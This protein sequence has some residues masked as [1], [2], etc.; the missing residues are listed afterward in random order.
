MRMDSPFLRLFSVHEVQQCGSTVGHQT[1]GGRQNWEVEHSKGNLL[2]NDDYYARVVLY[3]WHFWTWMEC[4]QEDIPPFALHQSKIISRHILIIW[5]LEI[6]AHKECLMYWFY[7]GI[8][9]VETALTQYL[10]LKQLGRILPGGF[11][12]TITNN[13]SLSCSNFTCEPHR[14]RY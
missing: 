5:L 14:S 2:N 13:H 1:E 9:S 11:A 10:D 3:L 8:Q 6:Q 7:F 12:K 4:Q